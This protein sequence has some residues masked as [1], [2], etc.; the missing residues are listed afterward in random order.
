M[1]E[2]KIPVS[3]Y[4]QHSIDD[5]ILTCVSRNEDLKKPLM[6]SFRKVVFMYEKELY[7]LN[8]YL[9]KVLSLPG[10]VNHHLA[11]VSMAVKMNKSFSSERVWCQ[12]IFMIKKVILI[13]TQL[14]EI[15]ACTIEPVVE[16]VDKNLGMLIGII[17]FT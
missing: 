1:E 17:V 13:L 3:A 8:K 6:S 9:F 14:S 10:I 11:F 16:N 12:C 5:V 15:L 7:L 2:Y 4:I